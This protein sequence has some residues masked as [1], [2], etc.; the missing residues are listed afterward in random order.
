ME[1]Q[2]RVPE[3]IFPLGSLTVKLQLIGSH[4]RY[5]RTKRERGGI[6]VQDVQCGGRGEVLEVQG[7]SSTRSTRGEGL[8]VL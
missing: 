1:D 6:V 5:T 8:E 4:L 7:G 3:N 2:T